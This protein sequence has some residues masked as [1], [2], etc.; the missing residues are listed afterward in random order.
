MK[1]IYLDIYKG[2]H[3]YAL[4]DDEDYIKVKAY[5]WLIHLT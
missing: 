2:E 4:I 1:K 5:N 3:L